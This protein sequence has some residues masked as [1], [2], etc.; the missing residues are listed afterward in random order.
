MGDTTK[1]ITKSPA[2]SQLIPAI[3]KD[4]IDRIVHRLANEIS[5]DYNRKKLILI[6]VL[7]GS[8]IFL[9]DLVRQMTLP[10][11][12]EF[13]ELSSYGG[14]TVSN[15]E[16]SM[17]K[18][19]ETEIKDCDVLIIEDIVDTGLTATYLIDYLKSLGP[20]TVK[21]CALLDKKA[22]READVRLDY[23]GRQVEDGF[24]VGYGLDYAEAYRNLPEICELQ[25]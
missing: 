12:I 14:K 2:I 24:L 23:V 10:V 22:R 19:I 8:F 25:L 5:S 18:G 3:K 9:S 4:E 1:S 11:K 6:A 17:K 13:I 21:I 15:R 16:I 20:N 7:K